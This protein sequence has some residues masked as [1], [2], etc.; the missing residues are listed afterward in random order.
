[1]KQTLLRAVF[2]ASIL[3]TATA[4]NDDDDDNGN[5]TPAPQ[6][7]F[8]GERTNPLNGDVT[9]WSADEI[10][11]EIGFF[12]S[13]LTIKARSGSDTLTIRI[14]S[15]EVRQYAIAFDEPFGFDNRYV[16]VTSSDTIVYSYQVFDGSFDGGGVINIT[17]IDTINKTFNAGME[18]LQFFNVENG[19]EDDD[20][21]ILQNA[22]LSNIS[23]TEETFDIGGGFGDGTMSFS[24]NGQNYS[25][26]NA[27]GIDDS[28]ELTLSA[29]N[30]TLFAPSVNLTMNSDITTG[31]YDI[32]SANATD[33]IYASVAIEN[34]LDIYSSTSGTLEITS[35]DTENKNIVGTFSFEGDIL[36]GT[37]TINVTNGNF[38]VDYE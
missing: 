34:L 11:A 8:T 37:E 19:P 32:G 38:N 20:S 1:M 35:H 5:P 24:A 27:T 22:V 7:S 30:S 18:G 15:L 21:F 28:G 13:D 2:F 36:F 3:L 6:S 17:S 23:Y 16:S 31:T 9:T 14:P 25:F 10:S 4:C 26:D 12:Q 33:P 29:F